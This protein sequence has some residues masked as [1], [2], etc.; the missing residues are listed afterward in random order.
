MFSILLAARWLVH[1]TPEVNSPPGGMAICLI[2]PHHL[3]VNT[4]LNSRLAWRRCLIMSMSG[5]EEGN[6][7]IYVAKKQ[8]RRKI[9]CACEGKCKLSASAESSHEKMSRHGKGFW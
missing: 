8:R 2:S 7:V 5:E 6:A 3:M 4:R 9:K 1:L